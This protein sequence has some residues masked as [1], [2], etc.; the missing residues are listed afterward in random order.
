MHSLSSIILNI[1]RKEVVNLLNY[2]Q[3]LAEKI[4]KKDKKNYRK[5]NKTFLIPL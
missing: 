1:V 4:W 2:M 3:I 5:I